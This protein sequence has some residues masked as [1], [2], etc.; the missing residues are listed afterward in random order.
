MRRRPCELGEQ[1]R[2]LRAVAQAAELCALLAAECDLSR[3]QRIDARDLAV[4]EPYS[5]GFVSAFDRP[6]RGVQLATRRRF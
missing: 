3:T 5:N 1:D 6:M 2:R 4:A